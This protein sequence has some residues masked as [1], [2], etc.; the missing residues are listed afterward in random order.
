MNISNSKH[1]DAAERAIRIG[2]TTQVSQ[3][4]SSAR[5]TVERAA[6]GYGYEALFRDI[7]ALQSAYPF[8]ETGTI[9]RSVMGRD[10]PFLRIGH[11]QREIH[12]N[13]SFHANEW[14]TSQL[15]MH[16]I[17]AYAEAFYN[18]GRLAGHAAAR[19]MEETSLWVVPMVNPD[20]VELSIHG[21]NGH[22]ARDRLIAWNGGSDD[23]SGWKANIRGVDL[24]DQFPAHWDTERER[25]E[26]D[27]PG[28]RDY[29]GERPLSEPEAVAMEQLTRSRDFRLVM[30]FHTQGKEIYWNYRDYEP[31]EA[32]TLSSRLEVLSGYKAIKLTGSDAGYKDWFIQE[33]RRPGFTVEAGFGVNPLPLEQFPDIYKELL[34]LL[35]EGMLL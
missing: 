28:P 21:A 26:V 4:T 9:G 33:F 22:P 30:A 25:R 15:L 6:E 23:F 35:T 20:G 16:F 2:Q 27:G 34:P 12:Y 5:P 1:S 31:G 13:G 10:I 14:I 17:A 11:G 3:A 7:R 29:T 18:G 8:I 32:E 19:L 24:N